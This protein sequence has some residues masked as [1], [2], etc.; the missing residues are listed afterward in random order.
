MICFRPKQ[1]W[2]Y[3]PDRAT[4]SWVLRGLFSMKTALAVHAFGI[5]LAYCTLYFG[6]VETFLSAN[7]KETT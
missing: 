2:H 1:S 3:N 4:R 7:F 6:N 5:K